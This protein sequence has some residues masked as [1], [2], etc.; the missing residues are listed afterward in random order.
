ME[1]FC[2][3]HRQC[4]SDAAAVERLDPVAALGI[5][6][7]LVKEGREGLRGESCCDADHCC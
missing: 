4:A 2:S 6:A 3:R 5:A 1:P 7:L